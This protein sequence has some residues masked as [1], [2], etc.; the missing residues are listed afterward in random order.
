M[1]EIDFATKLTPARRRI[2]FYLLL[3]GAFMPSFNMF[4]VT[5]AL[6]AIRDGFGGQRRL[7]KPGRLGLFVGLR[8]MPCHRRQA[9]R[10]LRAPPHVS[11]RHG[12]VRRH[13]AA[14]R[15]RTQ[16]RAS[17]RL[18]RASRRVR[19]ADGAAGPRQP[20]HALFAG[21]NP[22]GAQ[23]LWHRARGRGRR[24]A[25]PRRSADHRGRVGA[26]LA[27]GVPRQSADRPLCACR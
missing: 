24:G 3:L 23:Y 7:R 6:P 4:V 27:L 16:H 20:A 15:R 10:S 8:R 13:L 2:A 21:R 17:G 18:A 12:R 22:L 26:W 5:I 1:A 25:V 9:R 19:G 11:Y 14:V